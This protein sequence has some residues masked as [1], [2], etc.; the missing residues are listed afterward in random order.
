MR[1]EV[2]ICDLCKKKVNL[3]TKPIVDRHWCGEFVFENDVQLTVSVEVH[4]VRKCKRNMAYAMG[5]AEEDKLELCYK[6][7]TQIREM[8]KSGNI[9]WR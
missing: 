9:T 5:Y 1:K 3:G 8:L 7:R 4:F 2:E 6:C